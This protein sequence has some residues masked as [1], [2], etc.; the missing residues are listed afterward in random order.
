[1]ADDRR[2]SYHKASEGKSMNKITHVP[3]KSAF[4]VAK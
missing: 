4:A 3:T 1:M 2:K